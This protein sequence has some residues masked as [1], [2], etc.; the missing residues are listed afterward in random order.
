VFASFCQNVSVYPKKLGTPVYSG[1]V[2]YSSESY[3]TAPWYLIL[4][5]LDVLEQSAE[6]LFEYQGSDKR[7]EVV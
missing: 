3:C 4:G 5:S 2:R 1:R 6:G 7:L